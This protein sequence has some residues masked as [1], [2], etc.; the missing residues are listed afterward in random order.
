MIREDGVTVFYDDDFVGDRIPPQLEYAPQTEDGS[1]EVLPRSTAYGSDEAMRMGILPFAEYAPAVP[2]DRWK[3]VIEYCHTQQIFPVYHQKRAGL[4]PPWDQDGYGFC[5]AYGLTA[6]LMNV[7][8][9][10]GQA[11]VRLSPFSL[12]WLTNWRN[13]GFFMD[14]AIAGARQRGIAPVEYVPE[15][16]LRPSTFKPG[17]EQEALRYRPSEWWDVRTGRGAETVG[18]CLAILSCGTP[19][20]VGYDWWRHA[21]TLV[22][23]E[24]DERAAYKVT[25]VLWNSHNGGEFVRIGSARGVPD[26]AYGLRASLLTS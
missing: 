5:W 3:E 15:Y 16:N 6:A 10:E 7:R 13:A 23:L 18:E 4:M 20:Y 9:R 14:R 1:P 2:P 19:L 25:F 24:W 12:G 8:E 11:R 21:L 26:E 17:W 22:S